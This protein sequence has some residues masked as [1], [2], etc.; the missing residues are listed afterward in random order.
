VIPNNRNIILIALNANQFVNPVFLAPRYPNQDQ[1][2]KI[3]LAWLE[4][5]LRQ[6][7]AQQLLIAMHEEPGLDSNNNA[8]WR[9]SYLTT[10]INLL[11][12]YHT[13]YQQ[14]SLL[15]GHSHYDELRKIVLT[16]KTAIYSYSTPAIS[17][18]HYTNPAMKIFYLDKQQKL[19]DFTTYY[20][21]DE[22][23]W[24]NEQYHALLSTGD[25]IFP[26][27]GTY[28]LPHCLD[29]LTNEEVCEKM[30]KHYIFT[31]KNR[32]KPITNCLS[33]YIIH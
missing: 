20:T 18:N 29:L 8:V 3:Q 30:T 2:A 32:D 6:H 4:Q 26:N 31:V 25:T 12:R 27:C 16:D 24:Q 14:L 28:N 21:T 13:N 5:Q 11:N 22:Q 1:Q 23:H 7:H 19:V 17:R 10:F 15:P 9:S 33:S